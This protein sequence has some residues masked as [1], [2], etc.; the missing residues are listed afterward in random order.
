[1]NFSDLIHNWLA[2]AHDS[3][4]SVGNWGRGHIA[5]TT[6]VLRR[7]LFFNV[8]A[9]FL[10]LIFESIGFRMSWERFGSLGHFLVALAG[11]LSASLWLYT[12]VR[13]WVLIETTVKTNEAVKALVREVSRPLPSSPIE[14]PILLDQVLANRILQGVMSGLAAVS[15]GSMYAGF[16][17]VYTNLAGFLV[18]V[19]AGFMIAFG[20]YNPTATGA[21]AIRR[22]LVPI[23]IIVIVFNTA[24]CVWS[25]SEGR[26]ANLV[27][28]AQAARVDALQAEKAGIINTATARPD[29]KYDQDEIKRI[30]EIDQEIR[31][32][33]LPILRKVGETRTWPNPL[34]WLTNSGW[35]GLLVLGIVVI[36]IGFLIWP[37]SSSH[38]SH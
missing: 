15:F 18:T 5:T 27:K 19:T 38:A 30:D 36:L 32:T 17:P 25:F 21:T 2:H 14:L 23:A 10:G 11:T 35:V 22:W 7:A 4:L 12:W 33:K 6:M 37:K 8:V 20:T 31:E 34:E 16:I 24:L 26:N 1:M 28:V 3:F 13:I 29:H 9:L